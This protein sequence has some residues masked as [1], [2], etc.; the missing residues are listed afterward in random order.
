[1]LVMTEFLS[2]SAPENA[3]SPAVNDV[4][5]FETGK[6]CIIDVFIHQVDGFIEVLPYEVEF[7]SDGLGLAE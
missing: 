3:L 4:H 1:M 5:S 6:E 2:E 7:R